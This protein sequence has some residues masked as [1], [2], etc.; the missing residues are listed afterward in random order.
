MSPVLN[1]WPVTITAMAATLYIRS[2]HSE[3][4]QVVV[5][6]HRR[7]EGGL[8]VRNPLKLANSVN[9]ALCPGGQHSDYQPGDGGSGTY[10]LPAFGTPT[11]D[12]V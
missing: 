5:D 6:I 11:P 2:K 9:S 8:D 12:G 7:T 1:R 3:A 4:E 10:L